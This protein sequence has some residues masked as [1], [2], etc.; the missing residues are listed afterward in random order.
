MSPKQQRKCRSRYLQALAGCTVGV[1]RISLT[2]RRRH[3][4]DKLFIGQPTII[5]QKVTAYG[6]WESSLQV[7]KQP[8]GY[9]ELRQNWWLC[10]SLYSLARQVMC[11]YR[12]TTA[13]SRNHCCSG[14]S[15]TITYS[16]CEFVALGI[17]HAKRMRHIVV[18][19]LPDSTIFY[20]IIL[21]DKR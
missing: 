18:C 9:N 12:N 3:T 21:W 13:R 5:E 17:Q 15:V 8:Q 20:H 19:G 11:V 7:S 10:W 4:G 14:K 1:G 16:E 2:K 6:L